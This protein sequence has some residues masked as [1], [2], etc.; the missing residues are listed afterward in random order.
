MH[1]LGRSV[2]RPVSARPPRWMARSSSPLAGAPCVCGYPVVR[3]HPGG[4][5]GPQSGAQ[6]RCA[7]HLRSGTRRT[8]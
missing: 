8:R 5:S 1:S 7:I 6:S 3:D 2:Y 4:R